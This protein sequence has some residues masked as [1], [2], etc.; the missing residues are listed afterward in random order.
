MDDRN[1][2]AT[3]VF[4]AHHHGFKCAGSTVVHLLN[5]NWPERVLHIEHRRAD[6]RIHCEQVLAHVEPDRHVA[7]T[8]HLLRMPSPGQEFAH[9]HFALVRDPI[10]RL[11]STYKFVPEE[12]KL[13]SLSA[14]VAANA[15]HASDFHI[16]HLGCGD[17]E[18]DEGWRRDPDC[19]PL[20]SPHVLIGLV[21]RF[22]DSMFLLE[23]RLAAVGCAFDGSV[24]QRQNVGTAEVMDLNPE[25]LAQLR[26]MNAEDYLLLERVNRALDRELAAVDPEFHGRIE[27]AKRCMA[28]EDAKEPYLGVPPPQWTYL[29][30]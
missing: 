29:E 15:L 3:R 4:V 24:G 1:G 5:R 25:Q 18:H 12:R 28:R 11:V 2:S 20:E 9:V 30:D 22:A 8:S 14:F 6:R 10:A 26:A 16:R 27:Y 21:E 13:G 23:R 19:V 17:A 7:L